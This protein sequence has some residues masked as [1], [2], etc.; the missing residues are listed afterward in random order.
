VIGRDVPGLDII[1]STDAVLGNDDI[2]CERGT[3]TPT[4]DA[5][6]PVYPAPSDMPV[7]PSFYAPITRRKA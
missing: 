2:A 6:F 4:G 5:P 1:D 7:L 3:A